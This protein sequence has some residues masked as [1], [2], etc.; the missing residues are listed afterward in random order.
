MYP[1]IHSQYSQELVQI[2]ALLLKV[3]PAQRPNCNK[4]LKIIS[5]K[6][7]D[8]KFIKVEENTQLLNTIMIPSN[9]HFLTEQLPKA[10]YNQLNIVKIDKNVFFQSLNDEGSQRL[11]T[12]KA[13]NMYGE[14]LMNKLQKAQKEDS[15]VQLQLRNKRWATCSRSTAPGSTKKYSVNWK[16]SLCLTIRMKQ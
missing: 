1:R 6:M 16:R 15:Q 13:S 7:D 3:D 4:I 8:S 11:P 2:V 9:L 10:N 5:Q 14:Q 12:I